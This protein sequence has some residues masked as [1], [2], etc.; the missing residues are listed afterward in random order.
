MT[1]ITR[2]IRAILILMILLVSCSSNGKPKAPDN[3]PRFGKVSIK[4]FDTSSPEYKLIQYKL[5]T[6]YKRQVQAGFNGSVLI[7]YKG[8]VLYENYFGISQKESGVMWD[9]KTQSQ[10]A[11]TSKTLTSGA[12]L[13]LKDKGLLN[14][15]D[16]V[17]KYLPSFPYPNITVRMLLNH[18]SGLPDYIHFAAKPVGKLYLDNDDIVNLFATKK[19]ALKFTPNTKFNYSNSN[20]AM[21]ASIVESVSG[22]KFDYFMKRFVFTPLGM[23]NTF[24]I[25]PNKERVCTASFCYKANW[26]LDPEMH[27]DGVAGDKGIYSTVEDLYKWDQALY[28]N[29]FIKQSTLQEA[30]KP[31]S[32]ETGG[33]KNYGLGW[34]MLNYEDGSKIVYHNGWWHGNNTCFYRFIDDNFTII[35][36]GNKFNKSIYRQPLQIYNLVMGNDST[37]NKELEPDE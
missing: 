25:D 35:V 7:G 17:T 14:L 4:N 11:S 27:L 12:I 13:L 18:R 28:G 15:D 21:L 33:V 6:F 22:M 3:A 2:N 23:K 29:K 24:V 1:T 31:Y 5:D 8:H 20:F 26:Q 10:L 34:R 32:F 9:S 36:L 30:F 37:Y 16:Y 19:P